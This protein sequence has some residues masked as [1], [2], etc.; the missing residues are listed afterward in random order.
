[1]HPRPPANPISV[2]TAFCP[3][4]LLV[5][6]THTLTGW[7]MSMSVN[8]SIGILH[9]CPA[10]TE[11]RLPTGNIINAPVC[12]YLLSSPCIWYVSV[13]LHLC[14]RVYIITTTYA[15]ISYIMLTLFTHNLSQFHD[16][17]PYFNGCSWVVHQC[18]CSLPPQLPPVFNCHAQSQ[19]IRDMLSQ[20]KENETSRCRCDESVYGRVITWR[21]NSSRTSNV[22]RITSR[23]RQCVRLCR[24]PCK[25]TTRPTFAYRFAV[26]KQAIAQRLCDSTPASLPRG[27][28]GRCRLVIRTVVVCQGR[29]GRLSGELDLGHCVSLERHYRQRPGVHNERVDYVQILSWLRIVNGR[30]LSPQVV[31]S[32]LNC[33]ICWFNLQR[34]GVVKML[35]RGIRVN[36]VWNV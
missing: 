36:C 15:Y 26:I 9:T 4:R 32:D 20:H 14:P 11:L 19:H 23:P 16:K 30:F 8:M 1:M 27:W 33:F 35:R 3:T 29:L 17:R 2:S 7:S 13:Y 24:L 25:C 6:L 34:L 18:V 10:C 21:I 28:T 31:T 22:S 12:V 5:S